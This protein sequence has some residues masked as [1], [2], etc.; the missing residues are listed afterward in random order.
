MCWKMEKGKLRCHPRRV[1]PLKL[2]PARSAAL[3][4]LD[5][6]M[7]ILRKREKRV[8]C[9][10]SPAVNLLPFTSLSHSL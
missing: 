4:R 1:E 7:M 2:A 3:I 6:R 8:V 5:C 9:F 10:C